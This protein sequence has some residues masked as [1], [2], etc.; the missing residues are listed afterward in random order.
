MRAQEE[1]EL[2]L[3]GR[4]CH[5]MSHKLFMSIPLNRSD[6]IRI[7]LSKFGNKRILWVVQHSILTATSGLHFSAEESHVP[8]KNINK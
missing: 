3:H 2:G 4:D 5:Y 1:L 7:S 8:V 6:K